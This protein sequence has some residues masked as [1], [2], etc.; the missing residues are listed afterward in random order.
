M[1][2]N[3]WTIIKQDKWLQSGIVWMPLG[4]AFLLWWIFSQG[5]VRALPV[6]VVDLSHSE[7][8]RQVIR[9]INATS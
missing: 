1:T 9:N 4:L 7:Q 8:S 6:G 2:V 5:I 3:A